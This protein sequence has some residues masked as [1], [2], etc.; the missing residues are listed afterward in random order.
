ML[1]TRAIVRAVVESLAARIDAP[2]VLDPVL[3]SSSGGVLLDAEGQEA[4][5]CELLPHVT[6]LTPNLPEAA[7]LLNEPQAEDES[8]IVD[9]TLRLLALGPRAVLLK[10]GHASS[11]ESIDYLAVAQQRVLKLTAPRLAGTMRGTGCALSS[12][13]AAGLARKNSLADACTVAKDYVTELITASLQESRQ[14]GLL[15]ETSG[16]ARD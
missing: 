6:L 8:A 2:L 9:Q 4:L 3:V 11:V 5:R 12:A 15:H 10:G 7:A 14:A 13:I 1:G 16:T